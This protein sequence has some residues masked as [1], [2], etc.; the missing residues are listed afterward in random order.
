MSSHTHSKNQGRNRYSMYIR[1][2]MGERFFGDYLT[3]ARALHDALLIV[4][5][6]GNAIDDIYSITLEDNFEGERCWDLQKDGEVEGE[7]GLSS[8][9]QWREIDY[10]ED[11]EDDKDED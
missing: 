1:S 6:E 4:R 5:D 7:R 2:E 10:D 3:R 11:E 8:L 9:Y